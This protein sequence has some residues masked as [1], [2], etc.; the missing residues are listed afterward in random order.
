M[1]QAKFLENLTGEDYIMQRNVPEAEKTSLSF[2]IARFLFQKGFILRGGR[3]LT[4][5]R[6]RIKI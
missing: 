1:T 6:D 2:F 3:G 5:M 4:G